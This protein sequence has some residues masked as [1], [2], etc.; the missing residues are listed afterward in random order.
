MNLKKQLEK[1]YYSHNQQF[2]VDTRE[3]MQKNEEDNSFDIYL[4]GSDIYLFTIQNYNALKD[5]NIVC[6]NRFNKPKFVVVDRWDGVKASYIPLYINQ[7][8]TLKTFENITKQDI[9][10]AAYYY[11]HEILHLGLFFNIKFS[12]EEKK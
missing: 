8:I 4:F 2:I 9:L 12:E 1:Y 7:T 10:N 11:I 3:L 5:I 6:R